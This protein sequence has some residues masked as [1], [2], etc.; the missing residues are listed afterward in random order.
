[1]KRTIQI[2]VLGSLG[3]G[4]AW[5]GTAWGAN[6][7]SDWLACRPLPDATA[8]LA[9]Y[10]LAAQKA[11]DGQKTDA[12]K[13]FGLP[14]ETVLKQV[15]PAAT[16]NEIK[17]LLK[18]VRGGTAGRLV[19]ELDSGQV[20]EQVMATQDALVEP[21]QSVVIKSAALGSFMMTTP[22]GRSYKV[23]RIR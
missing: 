7:A 11:V 1:M 14:A 18:S 23:R 19:F 3:I 17:A 6:G 13:S 5:L 8:R 15:A 21:G 12:A 22:S 20:W 2:S 4:M 9:C 10:D 16:S